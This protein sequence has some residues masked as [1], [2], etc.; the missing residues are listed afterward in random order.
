MSLS[1]LPFHISSKLSFFNSPIRV[2]FSQST[3]QIETFKLEIENYQLRQEK[4][5]S[6][7]MEE[8]FEF[9]KSNT[10]KL[11][12]SRMEESFEFEKYTISMQPSSQPKDSVDKSFLE[13]MRMKHERELEEQKEYLLSNVDGDVGTLLND[14]ETLKAEKKTLNRQLSDKMQLDE[15]ISNLKSENLRLKRQVNA[16]S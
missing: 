6:S 16:R 3:Q 13:A 2:F 10:S 11:K 9:E 14:I 7:Q 12:S 5:E 8:S 4:L 1:F 15:E